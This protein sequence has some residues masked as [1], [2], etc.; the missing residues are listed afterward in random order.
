MPEAWIAELI[1]YVASILVAISLMM[2]S[3]WRLRI[4][5]L[6][7]AATFAIYGVLITSY[8][9]A[10][11]NIFIVLVNLYYL[12]GM[13]RTEE[14]FKLM[15]VQPDADYKSYFTDFYRDDIRR[16]IPTEEDASSDLN[17]F[18]LRDMVPAG[19]LT[20]RQENSTLHVDVD[21]VIPKFRDFKIGRYLFEAKAG[22][23]H[24]RGI[25]RIIARGMTDKHR[26]YLERMGFVEEGE[27]RF[28]LQLASDSPPD[29]VS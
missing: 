6:L 29:S 15:E 21:Y 13:M 18:V 3:I 28:V 20:G 17:L 16:F 23:F 10:I 1:G 11:V 7:G 25:H 24:R 8:P 22:F 12:R 2:S 27:D 19:L 26:D 5:N 4:I 14:F 9:V